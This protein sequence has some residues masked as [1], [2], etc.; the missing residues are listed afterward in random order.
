MGQSE[1]WITITEKRRME[2][3]R[4]RRTT[5]SGPDKLLGNMEKVP[6]GL[7][8]TMIQFWMTGRTRTA[9]SG[10]LS[11]VLSAW[12]ELEDQIVPITP[13]I[14]ARLRRLRQQSRIGPD[15]LLRGKSREWPSG[16]RTWM[17]HDW[18]KEGT[19]A[20]RD[21]LDYVIGLWE[22]RIARGEVRETITEDQRQELLRLRRR[23]KIGAKRMLGS[24]E[25]VPD[26]LTA[27][28]I[29]YWMTGVTRSARSD[30]LSAV[31]AAWRRLEDE[32]VLLTPEIR[33]KL[34]RLRKESRIGPNGLLRGVRHKMPDGLGTWLIHDWMNEGTHARRDH[35]E[36]V[37]GRWESLI[38]R[39]QIRETIT[40]AILRELRKERW[41]TSVTP[42][43][44]LKAANDLPRGLTS[45][46]ICGWLNGS[47]GSAQPGHLEYALKRWKTFPDNPVPTRVPGERIEL[48]AEIIDELRGLRDRSGISPRALFEGIQPPAG[49]SPVMVASWLAGTVET[50]L[51]HYVDF[52]REQWREQARAKGTSRIPITEEMRAQLWE[53]RDQ[54]GLGAKKLFERIKHRPDG[55]TPEMV[56]SWQSGQTRTAWKTHWDCVLKAW[57]KAAELS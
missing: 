51:K 42:H 57:Q 41:R 49:L 20:R 27:G 8:R 39:G 16:L 25:Q 30:H 53:L 14:R 31:L 10:H 38:K 35:L 52:V 43:K 55:L 46:I 11:A 21:H 28:I 19:H 47:S 40:P 45:G 12:R 17:V 9:R 2:L 37:V 36:F 54:S 24:M 5:N 7:T 1:G 4:L 34:N 6:E 23:T 32:T 18:L 26:G 15:G 56:C 29:H 33:E 50:A 48:T 3:R 44:L 13:E 22:A